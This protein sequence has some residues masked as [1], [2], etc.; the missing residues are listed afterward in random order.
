MMVIHSSLGSSPYIASK[1]GS[2]YLES[3]SIAGHEIDFDKYTDYYEISLNT[4]E[5]SLSIVAIPE[6]KSASVKIFNNDDLTKH[7][8][9]YIYVTSKDHDIRKYTIKYTNKSALKYF[10]SNIEE[11]SKI[12]ED[13]CIKYF[14]TNDTYDHFLVFTYDS[15][16][17]EGYPKTN[18]I[19]SNGK[20]VFKKSLKNGE[21]RNF[22]VINNKIIFTYNNYNE[23]NKIALYGVDTNGNIILNKTIINNNLKNLYTYDFKYENNNIY[24]KTRITNL[25]HTYIC[26]LKDTTV[27]EA[28][29][30]IEYKNNKFKEPIMTSKLNAKEYKI[31]MNINCDKS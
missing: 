31:I 3:L 5:T 15:L 26:S 2:S 22:N 28:R 27:V 7:D 6:N 25:T 18:I 13:Y 4:N 9:V 10:N 23:R 20:Q 12:E 1:E 11:C 14:N 24:L 19:T 16:T 30:K 29:Y 8:E 17:L 21:F